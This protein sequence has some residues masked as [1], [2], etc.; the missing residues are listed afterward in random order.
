MIRRPPIS[1]RTD[2]LFPYTT[3]FRSIVDARDLRLHDRA[4]LRRLG[5]AFLPVHGERNAAQHER[6]RKL[7]AAVVDGDVE[8][9][10]GHVLAEEHVAQRAV[11]DLR[12]DLQRHVVDIEVL[13]ARAL[14]RK[15]N[16]LN[17]RNSCATSQ[18]SSA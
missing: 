7:Q 13:L 2:T 17:S 11:L 12:R 1:T 10:G 9:R 14:D 5:K 18:T 15:S 4:H 6:P 16:R 3:L 8:L